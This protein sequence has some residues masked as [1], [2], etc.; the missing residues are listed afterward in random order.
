MRLSAS[1]LA[2]QGFTKKMKKRL[3]QVKPKGVIHKR[4]PQQ[5]GEGGQAEVDTCG[6]GGGGQ[7]KVDVHI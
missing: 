4:R 3:Y 6:H 5:W 7:A 1:A 2:L